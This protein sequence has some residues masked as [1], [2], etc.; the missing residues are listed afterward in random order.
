MVADE[1]GKLAEQTGQS[2][3]TIESLVAQMAGGDLL[4]RTEPIKS[5]VARYQV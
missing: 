1:V 5:A 2:T 4:L 3:S